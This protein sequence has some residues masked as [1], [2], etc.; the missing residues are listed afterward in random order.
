MGHLVITRY[1]EQSFMIGDDVEVTIVGV[2]G[3]QVKIS[4]DAP[5]DVKVWRKEL[6]EKIQEEKAP[7]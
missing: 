7:S 1:L 5:L 6:W 4:I 3:G 2:K